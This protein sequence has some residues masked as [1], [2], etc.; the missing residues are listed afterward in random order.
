M[1]FSLVDFAIT[2]QP[3]LL[4]MS[5]N[6]GVKLY[7]LNYNVTKILTQVEIES[8]TS[9]SESEQKK[10]YYIPTA[11]YCCN[12]VPAEGGIPGSPPPFEDYVILLK[13]EGCTELEIESLKSEYQSFIESN[14]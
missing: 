8:E 13:N 5:I 1:K 11:Q 10:E 2:P 9:V 12:Y 7:R 14:F 3:I 6:A 4:L